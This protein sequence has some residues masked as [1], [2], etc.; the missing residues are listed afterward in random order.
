MLVLSITAIRLCYGPAGKDT[1]L[2]CN[3]PWI[4]DWIGLLPFFTLGRNK[5]IHSC[6]CLF[7]PQMH[8]KHF[9]MA[10]KIRWPGIR[11]QHVRNLKVIK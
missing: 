7:L 10:M 9:K 3:K 8:V 11:W 1:I 2:A 6:Y 4:L 5:Q